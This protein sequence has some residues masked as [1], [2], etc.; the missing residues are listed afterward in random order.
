MPWC[1]RR[2]W[3]SRMAPCSEVEEGPVV[4]RPPRGGVERRTC[5]HADGCPPK[6]AVAERRRLGPLFCG[7]VR[8]GGCRAG[9][10]A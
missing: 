5:Q 1:P 3:T 2:S 4:P 7:C 6:V 9:C 8:G 10:G